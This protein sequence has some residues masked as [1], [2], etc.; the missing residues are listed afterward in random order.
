[1]QPRRVVFVVYPGIQTL[2]ISGPIEVFAMSCDET[3]Q[4]EYAFEVVSSDGENVRGTS[5]LTIGVDGAID[6]VRGAIDTLVIVGGNGVADA[7]FDEA[8]VSEIKRIATKARRVMSVCSGAFLLAEA[9]LLNGKRATTH[10][11][12]CELL[13][14]RYPSVT[15]DPDPIF[16]REGNVATSAGV[17]AGIDLAL[18]MVEEDL[19]RDVALAVA[20]RLVMFLRRPGTQSQFSAQMAGQLAERDPLRD[21]QRYIAEHPDAD[22]SVAALSRHVGMSERNFARCFR[23]EVGMTPARYVEQTRVETARRLLEETDDGVASVAQRAGFGTTETMRRTF[24][25]VL[26]TN[27][28]DY[29]R[30]F[31]AVA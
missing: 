18:A 27:P 31:R 30:R 15:V 3:S 9:G 5:G 13:A 21:A 2:D 16:V 26:R 12:A 11:S 17:T 19:G 6:D 8:L 14:Q 4:Q 23:D 7:I 28:H 24:L 22:L 10:W 29:R 25:R 20:R 1:M